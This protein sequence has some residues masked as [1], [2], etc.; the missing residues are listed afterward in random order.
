MPEDQKAE[1]EDRKLP[2][3]KTMKQLK[4]E[5]KDARKQAR[6]E[7]K[8]AKKKKT[9]VKK[10]KKSKRM[11]TVTMEGAGTASKTL[12][13][14]A[15]VIGGVGDGLIKGVGNGLAALGHKVE[16][17]AEVFEDVADVLD[18]AVDD[19]REQIKDYDNELEVARM[20]IFEEHK[21][22]FSDKK[23][24]MVY[25][26]D[27]MPIVAFVLMLVCA[28]TT[29]T[30]TG[31]ENQPF[32][33]ATSFF[34]IVEV[35]CRLWANTPRYF[36]FGY[37]KKL[38]DT[39]RWMNCIDFMLS[40]L[41]VCGMIMTYAMAGNS[42]V[43]SSAK[44]ARITRSIRMLKFMRMIRMV[45]MF[46]MFLMVF[47]RER[48]E[49][50]ERRTMQVNLQVD[51]EG[52]VWRVDRDDPKTRKADGTFDWN[53]KPSNP[54][55]IAL[56]LREGLHLDNKEQVQVLDS[57]DKN[58]RRLEVRKEMDKTVLRKHKIVKHGHL[59][60]AKVGEEGAKKI[61]FCASSAELSVAFGPAVGMYFR[62]TEL[63]AAWFFLLF[64]ASIPSISYFASDAYSNGTASRF[65]GT[66][67][68]GSGVCNNSVV[69]EGW[70]NKSVYEQSLLF[71]NESSDWAWLQEQKQ[72]MQHNACYIGEPQLY[73]AVGVI[74]LIFGM[75]AYFQIMFKRFLVHVDESVQTAQVSS[76]Q[77]H[78]LIQ[79]H[80]N[81]DLSL[82]T[83]CTWIPTTRT[84]PSLS[85]T[86]PSMRTTP[87]SGITTSR[88]SARLRR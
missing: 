71:S 77:A 40:F 85:M 54:K 62:A 9:E 88:S 35:S 6:S 48:D 2:K 20:K 45:R 17:V 19:A 53:G 3:L 75:F 43:S 8:E 18:D 72:E 14:T 46:R 49:C 55:T 63:F 65:Q 56:A 15:G 33:L 61:S 12:T 86:H 34:F 64:C 41:D 52:E 87:T 28:N 36:F 4:K 10:R 57:K 16:N 47:K 13:R 67:I 70:T 32:E 7:A 30:F 66:L 22:V 23:I 21:E 82:S 69:V 50:V 27:S 79:I 51:R 68:F 42:N 38:T 29:M 60:I 5:G 83:F 31:S 59:R 81:T 39:N 25:F 11:S 26:C 73:S 80:T 44:S 37:L 58:S 1:A 84:I 74:V 76:V 24:F 78:E